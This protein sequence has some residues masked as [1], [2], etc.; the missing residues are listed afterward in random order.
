VASL[1]DK[2]NFSGGSSGYDY[3][4]T[5]AEDG[6]SAQNCPG[7]CSIQGINWATD[8]DEADNRC[9][10]TVVDAVVSIEADAYAEVYTTANN[11]VKTGDFDITFDGYTKGTVSSLG[12]AAGTDFLGVVKNLD[13]GESDAIHLGTLS[14]KWYD[15]VDLIDEQWGPGDGAGPGDD[16]PYTDYEFTTELTEGD[17]YAFGIRM[18]VNLANLSLPGSITINFTDTDNPLDAG[19]GMS[20]DV[21]GADW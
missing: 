3:A 6:N 17:T 18:N 2:T 20:Y 14:S 9:G 8:T 12:M 19:Y 1:A 16:A 10:V 5:D 11:N 13:T 15:V 7:P 21:I 4:A